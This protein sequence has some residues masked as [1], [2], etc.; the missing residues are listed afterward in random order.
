MST[1]SFRS[2]GI[3][4]ERESPENPGGLEKRVALIPTDVASL[5]EAGCE[6][7]VEAGAGERIGFQDSQ[8]REAGASIV[9]GEEIYRDRDLLIKFKGP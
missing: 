6:V 9:K 7:A 2:I 4:R 5:V 1:G 3:A 8:Y